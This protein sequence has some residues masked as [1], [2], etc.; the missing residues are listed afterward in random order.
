MKTFHDDQDNLKFLELPGKT[1]EHFNWARLLPDGE[2]LP[3]HDRDARR[4][5]LQRDA[6]SQR[7]FQPGVQQKA[8]N[9]RPPLPGAL[10]G[11]CR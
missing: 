1:L 4:E 6:T 5:S 2:S 9:G 8:R 10:Q 3:S 7:H 11:D